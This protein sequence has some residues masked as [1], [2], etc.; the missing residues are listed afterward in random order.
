M[1]PLEASL[2]ATTYVAG[3]TPG[4]RAQPDRWL[5]LLHGIFGTGKNW[6]SFAKELTERRPDWGAVTV[7]LRKH[8]RSQDAP[9]PHTIAAC[10]QDLLDLE[11]SLDL[12]IAGISG[13]SFGGKVAL[14]TADLRARFGRGPFESVWILD[15][16]PTAAPQRVD[17][18]ASTQS[19][20]AVLRIL[21]SLP[22]LSFPSR[23]AFRDALGEHGILRKVA[24]W[25]GMN[26]R[27]EEDGGYRL[28]MDLD[29][30]AAL[31]DN[32]LHLDQWELLAD[33][34]STSSLHFVFGGRS[35]VLSA[36]LPDRVRGFDW[37]E[38]TATCDI[39]AEAGHRLHVD[40][41]QGLLAHFESYLPR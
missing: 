26:L 15:S 25:L 13:H 32:Y 11:E 8:G 30:L 20:I 9:P 35:T 40:D 28:A 22:S 39:L 4:D 24:D 5:F 38:R 36:G 14:A 19:A 27:A 1:S 34:P 2:H 37:G 17:E 31:L 41:P 6:H 12:P 23:T 33:L 3:T 29:S 18:A 21:R 7:D 10:A 16:D